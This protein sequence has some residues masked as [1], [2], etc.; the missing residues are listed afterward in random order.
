MLNNIRAKTSGYLL[1]SICRVAVYNIDFS[2]NLI[3]I[4]QTT[5]D[6]QPLVFSK[7]NDCYVKHLL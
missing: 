5:R 7:N 1:G 2:S 4:F 6:M 3:Y